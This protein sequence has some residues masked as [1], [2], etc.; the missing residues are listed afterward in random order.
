MIFILISCVILGTQESLS[1]EM[2]RTIILGSLFV[3][4]GKAGRAHGTA[5]LLRGMNLQIALAKVYQLTCARKFM[6]ELRVG[7]PKWNSP[8]CLSMG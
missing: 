2:S 3:W 7:A 6:A 5:I 1:K 8:E 4:P